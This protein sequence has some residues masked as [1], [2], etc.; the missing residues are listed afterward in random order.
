[1]PPVYIKRLAGCHPATKT[2]FRK[3]PPPPSSRNC[4]RAPWP[5]KRPHPRA[6]KPPVRLRPASAAR[7]RRCG[8]A[9]IA[10]WRPRRLRSLP[11]CTPKGRSVAK[12]KAVR[13]SWQA[14]I[15]LWIWFEQSLEPFIFK[16][17]EFQAIGISIVRRINNPLI[18][19]YFRLP[20]IKQ[21]R[22][23]H[24]PVVLN[25]IIQERCELCQ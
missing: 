21:S 18:V 12:G 2:T 14:G 19:S 6:G 15:S 3:S 1:M 17:I 22:Q 13:W 9:T 23:F 25:E 16:L 8:S 5:G 20:H 10:P 11:A 7:R 24:R 4:G